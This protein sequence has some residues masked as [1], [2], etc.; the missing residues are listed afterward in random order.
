MRGKRLVSALRRKGE[1][2]HMLVHVLLGLGCA[3]AVMSF[4]PTADRGR[5]ITVGIL[6]NL[7]PDVDHVLFW[8]LYGRKSDYAKIL[9]THL[10]LKQFRMAA[11][12]IKDNHKNNT[13]LY[14]HNI[15]SLM[16]SIFLAWYLGESKDRAGFYVFFMSW[17]SH[18]I[19]DMFEDIL[20][21]KKLNSNWF[22]KFNRVKKE[23]TRK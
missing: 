11:R 20:F 21:F 23:L 17:S 4:F 10:K 18:Y 5:L 15:L 1:Y 2:Y 7:V 16:L 19:F 6:G 13:G 12:F 14:S 22:M 3:Y 9:K 8:F